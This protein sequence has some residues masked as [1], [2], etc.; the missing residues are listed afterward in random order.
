MNGSRTKVKITKDALLEEGFSAEKVES[1]HSPIGL[2]LG[3]QLPE[4][5][6]VSIMAEIVKK[7]TAAIPALR[8]WMWQMRSLGENMESC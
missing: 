4:E 5:I 7:R 2:P 1:M 6:A 3:G 8:I